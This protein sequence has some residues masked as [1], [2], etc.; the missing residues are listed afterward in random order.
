MTDETIVKK[1]DFVELS[2]TGKAN[3][4]VFDSNIAEDLKTIAPDAKPHK[5]I[6]AVGHS[7]ILPAL[8]DAL[9]GKKLAKQYEVH[10][11]SKDAF[12]PRKRELI[13]V[14]PLKAFHA[15][16]VDPKPGAYLMLDNQPVKII[17]VSGARVTTDFNNRLA[18][19]DVDY[20]FTIKRIVN[21]EK[22]KV[23]A[24]IEYFLRAKV[25]FELK[26]N[27]VVLKGP[28]MLKHFVTAFK[29]K[30]QEILKKELA[31]EL[32]HKPEH[33]PAEQTKA[34]T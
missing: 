8:D 15:Q 18:G 23:E 29:D 11:A 30:A 24:F 3:G 25:P 28:E 31:F 22:E 1:D 16:K 2:F 21:E 27:K 14:I 26:D 12:G 6:I 10:I 5:V 7:M 4:E 17:A 19:K 20:V 33:K 9:V 32:E 34:S 13:R